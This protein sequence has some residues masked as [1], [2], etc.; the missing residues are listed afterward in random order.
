MK[1]IISYL[2]TTNDKN[3]FTAL[4]K[5][6]HECGAT[7]TINPKAMSITVTADEKQVD[8]SITDPIRTTGEIIDDSSL[9]FHITPI[10]TATLNE[11]LDAATE[12]N[13]ALENELARSED[14]KRHYCELCQKEANANVR[15]RK[16]IAAIGTLIDAIGK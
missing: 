3:S 9:D 10:D 12:R 4:A 14:M 1:K 16:Q 2:Y 13:K 6:V 8:G 11:A 15:I 7:V 5:L